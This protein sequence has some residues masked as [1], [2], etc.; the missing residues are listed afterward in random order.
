[1]SGKLI[2][3]CSGCGRCG[4]GFMS[5]AMR[6]VGY[7]VGHEV[8][9]RNGT[10]SWFSA[11]HLPN[12]APLPPLKSF[13]YDDGLHQVRNPLDAHESILRFIVR[14]NSIWWIK[15]VFRRELAIDLDT[16]R[17][18][19][20]IAFAYWLHWNELV[21]K[22]VRVTFRFR[23]EDGQEQLANLLKQN[24]I[25]CGSVRYQVSTRYNTGFAE[26]QVDDLGNP[27]VARVRSDAVDERSL[28]AVAVLADLIQPDLRVAVTEKAEAYGYQIPSAV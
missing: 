19:H 27:N 10:S 4:T 25:E 7:D 14:H 3:L 9:G 20:K 11:S 24:G 5:R 6:S 22:N 21:E 1:M 2:F 28:D 26:C 13:R 17:N 16:L 18:E 12:R 15:A 8:R 23:V